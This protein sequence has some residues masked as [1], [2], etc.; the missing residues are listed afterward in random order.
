[1]F[2]IISTLS[3]PH[4]NPSKGSLYLPNRASSLRRNT[5]RLAA[6]A[7]AAA[8]P[9]EARAMVKAP[10]KEDGYKEVYGIL[11]KRLLVEIHIYIYIQIEIHTCVNKSIYIYT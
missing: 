2:M 9:A 5:P 11:L 4:I 8:E 3:L 6:A 7:S 10:S 1:M